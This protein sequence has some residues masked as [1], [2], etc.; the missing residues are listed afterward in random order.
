LNSG[1][2]SP[3][4]SDVE[5]TKPL[6][7]NTFVWISPSAE[8]RYAGLFEFKKGKVREL[9]AMESRQFDAASGV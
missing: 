9:Y 4:F 5:C 8:G 6:T 7:K 3:A 1:T 2:W